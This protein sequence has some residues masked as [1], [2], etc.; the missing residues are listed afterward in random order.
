MD[1]D[2]P[3]QAVIELSL[4]TARNDLSKAQRRLRSLESQLGTDDRKVLDKIRGSEYLRLRMNARALKMRLRERLRVRKFE[5]DRIERSH[6]RQS[7]GACGF[8]FLS[9]RRLICYVS[10]QK[11]NCTRTPHQL[12][13][14]ENL[15]SRLC[16]RSITSCA[17]SL[18]NSYA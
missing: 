11:R 7:S 15:A 2:G 6:R 18:R 13:N 16:S 8:S 12:L 3:D 1:L 9:T 10:A 17:T 14:S 5:L 4:D